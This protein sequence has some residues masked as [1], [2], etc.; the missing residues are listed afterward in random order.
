VPLQNVSLS[1]QAPLVLQQPFAQ[2]AELHG[3]QAPFAQPLG[4]NEVLLV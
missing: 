4:Q 3:R 2:V 1:R